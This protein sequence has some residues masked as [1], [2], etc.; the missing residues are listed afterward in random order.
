MKAT[1]VTCAII[2]GAGRILLAQRNDQMDLPGK[3][4]FPG[5]KVR[6]GEEP[7]ACLIREVKEELGIE[8]IVREQL[9]SHRHSYKHISI[10]LLPFVCSLAGGSIIL[11]EHKNAQWAK[12]ENAFE[13]DLAEA[14][15]PVLKT[16]LSR[17]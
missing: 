12:P 1:K 4:E 11:H 6:D 17:K 10:E 15:I 16:Y 3:W 8:I 5:G 9:P 14:D 13:F 7:S 2:E